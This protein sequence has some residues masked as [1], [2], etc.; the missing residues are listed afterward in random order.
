[1]SRRPSLRMAVPIA[2]LGLCVAGVCVF[3]GLGR[4][5]VREDALRPADVVVVL[6]GGMPWRAEEAGKIFEAGFAR[7]VWVSRP[8]NLAESLSTLGIHYVGE[9]D[10]DREILMHEGVPQASIRVFE[11]PIVD[12]EQEIEEIAREMRRDGKKQAIIVTSPYHTRRVG[13]L[14]HRLEGEDLKAIVRGA[15]G[16]PYD[17]DHWWRDPHDAYAVARELMGLLNAWA[18]LPIRPHAS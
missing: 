18:G 9:E 14:W 16:D 10:Y 4:W 17:A 1:M 6:S 7:N 2:V 13:T 15:A 3:R 11:R 8:E 5:L 12:T